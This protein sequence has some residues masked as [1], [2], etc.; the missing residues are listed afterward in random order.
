M[1][2]Y[3]DIKVNRH[4]LYM[5][6]MYK[7]RLQLIYIASSF[8]FILALLDVEEVAIPRPGH[9]LSMSRKNCFLGW[10]RGYQSLFN[11]DMEK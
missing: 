5:M 4:G 7:V 3:R 10:S 2:T 11:I 8:K 6:K 9:T 1:I